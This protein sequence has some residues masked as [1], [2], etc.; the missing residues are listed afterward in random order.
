[1][2]SNEPLIFILD[3]DGTII[4]DCSYQVIL[5]NIEEICKKYKIKSTSDNILLNCYRPESKLIRPFFKYFIAYIRKHYPHSLFYV[6][7][8][9][10]KAW[11]YK[12]IS[13]IEKTHNFKFNRPI[14]TREDCIKDSYGQYRKSVKKILPKIVRGNKKYNIQS[15]KILVIDNNSTFIDYSSNF[16]LCPSY[17]YVL[18]CDVWEKMKKE[19]LKIMEIYQIIKDL[20]ANN[21][22]CRYCNWKTNPER[23]IDMKALENKHRWLYKKHKKIN[24]ENKKYIGDTFWKN[25]AH[26][27]I[28][29]NITS[30]DK[31]SVE[32]LMKAV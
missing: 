16:L 29:K 22:I 13:M 26:T 14:F 9:S 1:M 31:G 5:Y 20:I 27:I 28:D 24:Q 23:I 17:N 12:E 8:A 18:F 11:A 4:G 21:K 32:T 6:Y 30:F 25:L 7:T 2:T 3:L 19:Y 10:D 15:N